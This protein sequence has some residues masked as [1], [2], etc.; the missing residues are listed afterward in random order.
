MISKDIPQ[1]NPDDDNSF[2]AQ[3][4]QEDE[5]SP[6]KPLNREGLLAFVKDLGFVETPDM[7]A[8]RMQIEGVTDTNEV[9]NIIYRYRI[10]SEQANVKKEMISVAKERIGFYLMM[11][12][13]YDLK[14]MK[15]D[16]KEWLDTTYSYIDQI[17]DQDD[18][19]EDIMDRFLNDV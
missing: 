12:L 11:A 4:V 1:P 9:E 19:F 6:E 13:L 2:Q 17:W 18:I 7:L 5:E 14:G 8:L 3:N 15:K 10:Q 16:V